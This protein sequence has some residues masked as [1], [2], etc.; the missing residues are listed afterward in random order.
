MGKEV[1]MKCDA[2]GEISPDKHGL[3]K[4]N[5]WVKILFIDG[6]E[7]RIELDR[8]LNMEWKEDRR[9]LLLCRKCLGLPERKYLPENLYASGL[10]KL[11]KKYRKVTPYELKLLEK[12]KKLKLQLAQSKNA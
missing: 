1:F 3:Y 4:S 5:M 2:C 8:Y 12:I 6:I 10:K 11:F 9:E 7:T